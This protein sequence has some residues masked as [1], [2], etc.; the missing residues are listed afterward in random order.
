MTTGLTV[1]KRIYGGFF[2]ILFLLVLVA[3]IGFTGF[4]TV[5]DNVAHYAK[6]ATDTVRL[7]QIDRDVADLRRNVLMFT[8]KED[9]SA[10]D[11]IRATQ[12]SLRARLDEAATA[13]AG[14]DKS[15]AIATM[16][17]LI[18]EYGTL[19]DKGV[20]L[21]KRKAYLLNDVLIPV[22]NQALAALQGYRDAV[23]SR[24]S[25]QVVATGRVYE[26]VLLGRLLVARF[27]ITPQAKQ[28]EEAK[29]QLSV[30]VEKLKALA[31]AEKDPQFRR[32][33]DQAFALMSQYE[34]NFG[35]TV[36][37]IFDLDAIINKELAPRGA[38][39][40]EPGGPDPRR[41][42]QGDGRLA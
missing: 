11:R 37:A 27:F 12:S 40:A 35:E 20:D 39:F 14:S 13:T 17:R 31:E 41:S 32:Q 10:L 30:A 16:S 18:G 4:L 33:A 42:P 38:R 1:R 24:G 5:G 34:Q 25:E 23:A 6:E 36:T 9:A 26:H 21:S 7:Q 8:E 2:G 28:A 19:L 15:G 3:G 22:G 29:R